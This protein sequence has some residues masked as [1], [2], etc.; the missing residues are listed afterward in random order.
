MPGCV[1]PFI[2]SCMGALK[3]LSYVWALDLIRLAG[4]SFAEE[5]MNSSA[6][7]KDVSENGWDCSSFDTTSP[8]QTR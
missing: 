4:L 6:V 5:S 2:L 7:G 8:L 1:R 3:L